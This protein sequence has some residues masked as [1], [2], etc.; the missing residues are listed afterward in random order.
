MLHEIVHPEQNMRAPSFSDHI[1]QCSLLESRLAAD[2]VAIIN[3][4]WSSHPCTKTSSAHNQSLPSSES[5]A[6]DKPPQSVASRGR[7]ASVQ[8]TFFSPWQMQNDL[9]NSVNILQTHS[10]YFARQHNQTTG[11]KHGGP[12]P[13]LFHRHGEFS[14][15]SQLELGLPLLCSGLS[16]AFTGPACNLLSHTEPMLPNRVSATAAQAKKTSG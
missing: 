8:S 4:I 5:P 3:I 14:R 1:L 7:R 16:S 6:P 13:H 11:R 10:R 2:R 15:L 9:N 12:H